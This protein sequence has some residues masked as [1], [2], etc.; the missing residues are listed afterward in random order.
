MP[1]FK[2]CPNCED[3]GPD[4]R[5]EFHEDISSLEPHVAFSLFLLSAKNKQ[6]IAAADTKKLWD[7]GGQQ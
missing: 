6:K 7:W 5:L 3:T 1:S 4:L 2:G